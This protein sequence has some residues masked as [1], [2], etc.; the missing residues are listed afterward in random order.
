MLANDFFLGRGRPRLGQPD[1]GVTHHNDVRPL[2]FECRPR[3]LLVPSWCLVSF[4]F[5]EL[6]IQEHQVCSLIGS[7]LF[8]Y[9]SNM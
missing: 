6:C 8:L 5:Q 2:A 1:L 9:T 3:P 4:C 7:V